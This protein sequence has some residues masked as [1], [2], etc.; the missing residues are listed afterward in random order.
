[1]AMFGSLLVLFTL[2]LLHTCRLRGLSFRPLARPAFWGLV[3]NFLLLTWVGSQPVE[4]PF[5]LVG[6]LASVFY[7]A[8]FIVLTPLLGYIENSLLGVGEKGFSG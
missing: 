5:I 2:P 6:Q 3:A 7:F 8:Y 4:D 1:M